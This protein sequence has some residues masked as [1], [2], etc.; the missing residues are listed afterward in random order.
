M[1]SRFSLL[2]ACWTVAGT[3]H[4]MGLPT[5]ILDVFFFVFPASPGQSH[6]SQSSCGT[7]FGKH[8]SL[9]L[10]LRWTIAKNIIV[11]TLT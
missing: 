7:G 6:K 4:S 5:D 1:S 8:T 2:M 10:K 9:A 11:F 3:E